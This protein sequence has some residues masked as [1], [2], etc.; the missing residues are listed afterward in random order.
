MQKRSQKFLVMKLKV[1]EG[2]TC[3]GFFGG[4]I[5]LIVFPWKNSLKICHHVFTT[6]LTVKFAVSKKFVT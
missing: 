5:F 6:F 4:N 2:E 3:G 1:F